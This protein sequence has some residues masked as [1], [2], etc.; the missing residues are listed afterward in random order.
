MTIVKKKSESESESEYDVALN[1]QRQASLSSV[2]ESLSKRTAPSHKQDKNLPSRLSSKRTQY[3]QDEFRDWQ[4]MYKLR[5]NSRIPKLIAKTNSKLTPHTRNEFMRKSS[6]IVIIRSKSQIQKKLDTHQR[7]KAKVKEK[8]HR[9]S[10]EDTMPPRFSY[11]TLFKAAQSLQQNH[12]SLRSLSSSSSSVTSLE[13]RTFQE[14]MEKQDWKLPDD[15]SLL[16]KVLKASQVQMNGRRRKPAEAILSRSSQLRLIFFLGN[17]ENQDKVDTVPPETTTTT[18]HDEELALI[19]NYHDQK[20]ARL[21][22]FSTSESIVSE[23]NTSQFLKGKSDK[24]PRDAD[25][26]ERNKIEKKEEASNYSLWGQSGAPVLADKFQELLTF[27]W[28]MY[29]TKFLK[30]ADTSYAKKEEPLTFPFAQ[31]PTTVYQARVDRCP[32]TD[33][34]RVDR[35]TDCQCCCKTLDGRQ[36]DQMRREKKGGCLSCFKSPGSGGGGGGGYGKGGGGGGGAGGARGKPSKKKRA[37]IPIMSFDLPESETQTVVETTK[38]Q[39]EFQMKPPKTEYIS[40]EELKPK[41]APKKPCHFIMDSV[42]RPLN[43]EDCLL[44][45]RMASSGSPVPILRDIPLSQKFNEEAS[46]SQRGK[47]PKKGAM[48]PA[49]K[50]SASRAFTQEKLNEIEKRSG[51]FY[52]ILAYVYDKFMYTRGALQ[53][54]DPDDSKSK[55]HT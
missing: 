9:H 2:H 10:N 55:A 29:L 35:G 32:P 48:Q 45:Q 49:T 50:E 1:R 54:S 19:K 6:S 15:L 42:L 46:G 52:E 16:I 27:L 44:F 5:N 13:T 11:S 8:Q 25:P 41:E 43:D 18:L 24:E 39:K 17:P 22:T 34:E 38:Q 30:S 3:R 21:Q 40:E 28:R 31:A 53:S 37:T 26:D 7:H 51:I 33:P 14:R 4:Q 47:F 20:L 23:I 36:A 12:T